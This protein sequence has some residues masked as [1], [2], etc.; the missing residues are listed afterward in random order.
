M[1]E[2]VND[3]VKTKVG[4]QHSE[5]QTERVEKVEDVVR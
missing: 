4:A 5:R 2:S 3:E 1:N